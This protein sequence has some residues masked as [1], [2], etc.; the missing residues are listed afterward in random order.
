MV[1]SIITLK[2]VNISFK[3]TGNK[4]MHDFL[5]G[6]FLHKDKIDIPTVFQT[7]VEKIIYYESKH[8][9]NKIRLQ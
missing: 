4:K 9:T 2:L 7:N 5:I 8:V 3:D 1:N 6:Q